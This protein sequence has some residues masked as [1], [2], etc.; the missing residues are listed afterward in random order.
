MKNAIFSLKSNNL[1]QGKLSQRVT[2]KIGYPA[3]YFTSKFDMELGVTTKL[4]NQTNSER[5]NF[6]VY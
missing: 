3:V 1:A 5:L 2:P 6:T 4:K